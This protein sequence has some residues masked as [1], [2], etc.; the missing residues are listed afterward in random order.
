MSSIV[1]WLVLLGLVTVLSPVLRLVIAGLFGKQ[2][3]AAALAK[4]PD[5][6]HLEKRDPTAWR[7][8]GAVR[9]IVGPL[10]ARGFV[11]VGVHAVREMPGLLIQMLA[12]PKD[13]FYAAVYEHPQAGVW[14]DL[15]SRF[16]DG[17][18]ITFTTAR[19]TGL[20]PRPGHPSVNLTGVGP[21]QVL[22]KALTDRPRQWLQ[23]VSPDQAVSTFE[24]AY[25]ESAA[26]RKQAGISTREV[27]KT[28]TR[29]AA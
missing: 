13:G 9:A 1:F 6:I 11:D 28:A 29:K 17:T 14:F 7:N 21:T 18:S 2:I 5:A 16:Q 12:S 4:Q 25:A 23:A 3:G 27:V 19:P 20:D 26:Y 15:F 24:K 8:A 22:D 10:T